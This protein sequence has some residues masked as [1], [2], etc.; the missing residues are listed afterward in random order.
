MLLMNVFQMNAVILSAVLLE[1]IGSQMLVMVFIFNGP[2]PLDRGIELAIWFIAL[3]ALKFMVIY[4]SSSCSGEARKLNILVDKLSNSCSS[5][6]AFKKLSALSSKMQLRRINFNTGLFNIA[7]TIILPI[8]S[9]I[10]TYMV[11]M[12]QFMNPPKN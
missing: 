5:D 12:A 9:T 3:I 8:F 10:T 7:W 1:M 6:E 2:M 4:A 11:I